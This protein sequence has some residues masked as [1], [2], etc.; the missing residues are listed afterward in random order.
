MKTYVITYST[1]GGRDRIN[2][3][4]PQVEQLK[5]EGRWPKNDRGE[6]YC[7][8]SHGKHY[9]EMSFPDGAVPDNV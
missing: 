5:A 8:I 6:E 1:P 9:G 7:Q 2:L 4:P 3:T